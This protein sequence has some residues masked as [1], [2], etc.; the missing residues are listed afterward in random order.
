MP[1]QILLVQS[2]F[3]KNRCVDDIANA[4]NVA[5]IKVRA[6]YIGSLGGVSTHSMLGCSQSLITNKSKDILVDGRVAYLQDFLCYFNWAR[7]CQICQPSW[8]TLIAELGVSTWPLGDFLG[9]FKSFHS[10]V[11]SW[12]A[13]PNFQMRITKHMKRKA[14]FGFCD[15][16]IPISD[17]RFLAVDQQM[18]QSHLLKHCMCVFVE[19]S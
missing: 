18:T 19:S 12:P 5:S 14:E 7:A 1:V 16:L 6:V 4:L 11:I 3:P 8:E 17:V 2:L 10:L 15:W 9:T 13:R